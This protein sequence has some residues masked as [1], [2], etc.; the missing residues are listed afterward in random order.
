MLEIQLLMKISESVR[1]P[2]LKEAREEKSA[3]MK[4]PVRLLVERVVVR[5]QVMTIMIV[6]IRMCLSV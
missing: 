4:L 3:T 6:L 1:R 2:L 5:Q